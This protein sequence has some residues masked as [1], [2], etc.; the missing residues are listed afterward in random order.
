MIT[1]Q[2]NNSPKQNHTT[3]T[4]TSQKMQSRNQTTTIHSNTVTQK[5]PPTS[6]KKH[7]HSTPVTQHLNT[8]NTNHLKRFLHIHFKTYVIT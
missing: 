6:N 8:K 5:T 1:K 7:C 3:K 2:K 4:A